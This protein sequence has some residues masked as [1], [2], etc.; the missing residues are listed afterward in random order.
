[1]QPLKILLVSLLPLLSAPQH[2]NQQI[3]R[4]NYAQMSALSL[5]GACL[6]TGHF[7]NAAE[8]D[9]IPDQK[10][11]I[12][13]VHDDAATTPAAAGSSTTQLQGRAGDK[14]SLEESGTNAIEDEG[15]PSERDLQSPADNTKTSADTP[16]NGDVGRAEE[17]DE[18]QNGL[19]ERAN[20]EQSEEKMTKVVKN[21]V[22][23]AEVPNDGNIPAKA[24]DEEDHDHDEVEIPRREDKPEDG[25]RQSKPVK[26][27]S[28]PIV[29]GTGYKPKSRLDL[30]CMRREIDA[31]EH[32]TDADTGMIMYSPFPICKETNRPLSFEFG[33]DSDHKV[34]C[35]FLVLDETYHLLQLYVHQD[36]PLSC[37]IPARLGSENLFAPVVFSVQ[38]KLEQSHLD[39]ATKFNI[40]FTYVDALI[41]GRPSK[42]AGANITSAVAY[43]IDPTSTKRTIIGDEL[44]LQ[45][46]VRWFPAARAPKQADKS[47]SSFVILCY[48]VASAVVAFGV[49]AFYFLVIVFPQRARARSAMRK[50]IAAGIAPDFSIFGTGY[51]STKRD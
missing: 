14:G 22:K 6:I 2:R 17:T 38:G 50:A 15:R 28:L 37:Q 20:G 41:N 45:F 11:P 32:I 21:V 25:R 8:Q 13:N 3:I 4:T 1:M 18:L 9:I 44:T 24:K 26:R 34:N 49:A 10:V 30:A 51:A 36:A 33:V 40:V 16:A 27:V 48:C 29:E 46:N 19:E 47:V 39:I 43:P 35:T 23:V 12:V 5:A 42:N 31:G 7:V